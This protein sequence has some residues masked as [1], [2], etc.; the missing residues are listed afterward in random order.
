VEVLG[1]SFL[2]GLGFTTGIIAA[3]AVLMIALSLG[4]Y[5]DGE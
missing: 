5:E 1:Q 4:G 2:V 3:L